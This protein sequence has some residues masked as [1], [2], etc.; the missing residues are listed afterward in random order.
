[1]PSLRQLI[2]EGIIPADIGVGDDKVPYGNYYVAWFGRIKPQEFHPNTL[3]GQPFLWIYLQLESD[4]DYERISVKMNIDESLNKDA[5]FT[6][7]EVR[8]TRRRVQNHFVKKVPGTMRPR[9]QFRSPK[10][11][12]EHASW[13]TVTRTY[14]DENN[15]RQ[16][17]SAVR[18]AFDE[19]KSD[20]SC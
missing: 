14:Y 3:K 5:P 15:C 10:I 4:E 20:F 8:E 11:D 13:L 12:E 6:K 16:V 7:E 2:D 18:K 17:I 1:M 19:L 9:F